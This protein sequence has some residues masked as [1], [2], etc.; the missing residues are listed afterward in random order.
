M[1]DFFRSRGYPAHIIN[2]AFERAGSISRE[3][4]LKDK[5]R[6]K[7][8]VF[9]LPITFSTFSQKLVGAVIRNYKRLRLDP[10]MARALPPK[11]TVAYRRGRNIRNFV[12]KTKIQEDTTTV[13]RGTFPCN[14]SNCK[15][16]TQTNNDQIIFG[17]KGHT[18]PLGRFTCASTDV[19]YVI[20]CIKCARVAY[21]GET[22]GTAFK[23][24]TQHRSDITTR[25]KNPSRPPKSKVAAHFS[26]NN[27][28]EDD[29]R[30]AIVK[31]VKD[32]DKRLAEEQRLI[33]KL[34]TYRA[35]GLNVQYHHSLN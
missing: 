25:L 18:T 34:Q 8:D 13:V 15:M 9:T 30:V 3:D 22:S 17:P 27:H 26:E 12:T 11:V 33:Y 10:E 7:D 4:L 6:L 31:Q 5:I 16:C 28:C 29:M 19:I 21:V 23:R 24:I 20:N 1:K 14:H 2:D 32:L 35:E